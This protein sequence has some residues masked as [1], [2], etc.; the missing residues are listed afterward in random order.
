[1]VPDVQD[2]YSAGYFCW[3]LTIWY[4]SEN[5]TEDVSNGIL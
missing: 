3:L 5:A 4:N 2:Y 1:M